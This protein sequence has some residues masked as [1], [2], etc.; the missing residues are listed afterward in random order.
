V[1]KKRG[2]G[3]AQTKKAMKAVTSVAPDVMEDVVR[4]S[5]T[6]L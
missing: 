6:L 5:V 4:E 1:G 2:K 3:K